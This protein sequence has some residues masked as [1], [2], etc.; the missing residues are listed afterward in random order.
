MKRIIIIALVAIFSS[1][2]L[3]RKPMAGQQSYKV[4]S[5]EKV[6]QGSVVTLD[7][8]RGTYIL[9]SDTLKVNDVIQ[10]SWVGRSIKN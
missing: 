3:S 6:K 8:L 5:V 4:L 9:P 1:C 10:V 2:G 7:G